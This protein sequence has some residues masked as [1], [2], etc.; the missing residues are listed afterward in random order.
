M[1]IYIII[2]YLILFLSNFLKSS[3]D[4]C[5]NTILKFSFSIAD[6]SLQKT[7]MN[8]GRWL[9]AFLTSEIP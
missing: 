1:M 7:I 4:F 2:L 3:L 6:V 9:N 8:Y 5:R